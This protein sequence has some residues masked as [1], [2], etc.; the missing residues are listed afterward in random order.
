MVHA[1]LPPGVKGLPKHIHLVTHISNDSPERRNKKAPTPY[2][3]ATSDSYTQYVAFLC[4]SSN[5][6]PCESMHY[7]TIREQ[8]KNKYEITKKQE[9]ETI[10]TQLQEAASTF[11]NNS[12]S[13][14]KGGCGGLISYHASSS[15]GSNGEPESH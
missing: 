11:F 13:K 2:P 7:T 10:P 14:R 3:V 1:R 5:R 15:L 8:S 4:L 6:V 9:M 12:K